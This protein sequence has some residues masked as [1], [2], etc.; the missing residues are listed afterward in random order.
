MNKKQI[1]MG[2]LV[3]C[4]AVFAACKT[5]Q[6]KIDLTDPSPEVKKVLGSVFYNVQDAEQLVYSN[7]TALMLLRFP[8]SFQY[9]FRKIAEADASVGTGL[10][11]SPGFKI[12]NGG[13]FFVRLT[14]PENS[15]V[16][17]LKLLAYDKVKLRDAKAD[18]AKTI[19]TLMKKEALQKEKVPE[20]TIGG[21]KWA[22]VELNVSGSGG[23]NLTL[24][25]L[26]TVFRNYQLEISYSGPSEAKNAAMK[27]LFSELVIDS[28]N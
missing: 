4:V 9:E 16:I 26:N 21:R 6:K 25:F 8:K 13:Y 27:E 5:V 12:R 3:S 2:F 7:S 14:K 19:N 24:Y 22:S 23:G 17:D 11:V 10:S 20:E 18:L 15:V 28:G 1:T